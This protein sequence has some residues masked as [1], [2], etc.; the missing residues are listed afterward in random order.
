MKTKS[1]ILF[2]LPAFCASLAFLIIPL[3]SGAYYSFTDWNGQTVMEFVGLR[4]Y[5]KLFNDQQ[6]LS[7]IVFTGKFTIVSIVLVNIVAL[8]LAVLVTRNNSK[9]NIIFRTI[10][11]VPNLIGGIILGFIWQFI[12]L[13]GFGAIYNLTGLTFFQDWL[14]NE[15]TGFWGIVIL[16]VW[17]MSGYM[18]VIYISF[19]NNVPEELL[20]A[21]DI[22]GASPWTKFWQI[23]FPLIAPAFTICLFLTLS[24]AFKV[25]DQNLALTDGGPYNSTQMVAMNIYNEAFQIQNM[26]YAQT[27]AMVFLL[28]ILVIS[29]I[30]MKVTGQREIDAS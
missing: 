26:G 4:N 24:S 1:F 18:M 11:F 17:Q 2:L 3:V 21:A 13:K 30:Q 22:D 20:E 29:A 14:S 12:F 15:V 8:G 27:K 16:F 6:F 25:Y 10:F 7:S 28:I 9:L 23:K 5:V 19:L